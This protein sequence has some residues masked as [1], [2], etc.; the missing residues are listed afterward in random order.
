MTHD[1]LLAKI[2]DENYYHCLYALKAVVELTEQVVS[3]TLSR[4]EIGYL[5]GWNDAM[6]KIKKAIEEE[7]K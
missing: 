7:L 4:N 5:Y 2:S 3:P 1:E 6:K